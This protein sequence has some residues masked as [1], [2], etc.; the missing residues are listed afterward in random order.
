MIGGNLTMALPG[1]KQKKGSALRAL[2]DFIFTFENKKGEVLDYW[3][4]FY[5]NLNLPPEDFYSTIGK[6][7]ESRQVPSMKISREAFA[8]GAMLSGQRI[9]L[10]FFRERL[11]I[12]T[13][14]AP[15]GKGYFLSCRVVYVPALVRLWHI[16]AA[17]IFSAIFGVL[18]VKLLG[19]LFAGIALVTFFFAV[20]AVMRNASASGFSDLDT[21]LL[22]IPVVAT[23][24]DDWF[25]QETYFREDTRAFYFNRIPQVVRELAAQ[26]TAE[27]GAKLVQQYHF[28]PLMEE[29]YK[30]AVP[31]PE[32][33]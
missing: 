28:T 20:A 22:K 32:Q 7:F 30:P 16:I 27:K 8:E 9:Y 13:C 24:Y 19:L 15:F 10:R 1:F 14:A 33:H 11:A 25:R 2:F 18:L 26:L 4:N 6:E 12:Y 31:K 17:L 21:L 5:D 23:I 3:I 29:L